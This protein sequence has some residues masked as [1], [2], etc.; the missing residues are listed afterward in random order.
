LMVRRVHETVT[1]PYSHTHT[2]R[3]E[4][5]GDLVVAVARAVI[6]LTEEHG[7][8]KPHTHTHTRAEIHMA[9]RNTRP[10]TQH[11]TEKQ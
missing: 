11:D 2:Q 1:P 7:H 8:T 4:T 10:N 9:T 3:R 5:A 6:V